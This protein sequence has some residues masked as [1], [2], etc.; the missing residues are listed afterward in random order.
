MVFSPFT[1]DSTVPSSKSVSSVRCFAYSSS[2]G[3]AANAAP[4]LRMQNAECRIAVVLLLTSYFSLL[5]SSFLLSTNAAC[6]AAISASVSL[7]ERIA[8]SSIW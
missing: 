3:P 7:R 5:T 1:D 4:Q 8:H 6:T 2:T